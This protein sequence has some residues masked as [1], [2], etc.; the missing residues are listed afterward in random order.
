[1]R[2]STS[3][4]HRHVHRP[5]R[6]RLEP[7][8]R[9][10]RDAQGGHRQRRRRVHHGRRQT[11]RHQARRPRDHGARLRPRHPARQGRRLR[12]PDQHRRQV[13]RR[14][15]PVLGRPQRR[16]HQGGQRP[17]VGLRGHQLPRGQVQAGPL[18]PG[19]EERRKGRQGGKTRNG[20]FIRF[21][22][23]P[24]IFGDFAWQRGVHRAPAALLRLPQQRPDPGLQRREV[25]SEERPRRPARR[26]DRRRADRLRRHALQARP[27]RVRLHPHPRLRRDLLLLRQR[28][29]HQRRRHPPE[30]LPRGYPQGGQRVR[31]EQFRR[32]GRARRSDRRG[33]DQGPGPGLREPDQEQARLHRGPV[34][35][36]QRG[37][38]AGGPVAAQEP[39][40]GEQAA[41]QGQEQRAGAQGALGDQEGGAG[42]GQEGRHPHPQADR[43]QGS[44]LRLQGQA[45]RGDARSSSPRATRPA[46][47]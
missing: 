35:G 25:Q 45:P 36:R 29:V 12:L 34:V 26:R 28:P 31:Q 13:Q 20:T 19:Q 14:R 18:Q 38:G 11:G 1:M 23:D 9:H 6:R 32:R 40:G 10:L 44:P 42:T 17:V 2:S 39:G 5:H 3:A 46:A 27:A 7:C 37:E 21:I 4:A 33:R 47:P 24:E 41:R 30:R 43:L 22:P 16:R 8:R 15:L